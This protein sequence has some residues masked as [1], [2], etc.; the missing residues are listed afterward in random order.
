LH[1]APE[2]AIEVLSPGEKNERR[3]R[4]IK[5]RLY[6]R[7]GVLEYWVVDWQK[8]RIEVYRRQQAVLELAA[9]LY[10]EDILM[11]PILPGFSCQVSELF[12]EIL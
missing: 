5:L 7:H 12:D 10:E 2:L 4:E 1:D 9:T 3:D 11:S 6:S 8:R